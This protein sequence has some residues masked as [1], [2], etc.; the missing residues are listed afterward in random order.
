MTREEEIAFLTRYKIQNPV[1]YVHKFG[2]VEPKD[3]HLSVPVIPVVEPKIKVEIATKDVEVETPKDVVVP[4]Q[5]EVKVV[6]PKGQ[7]K[8]A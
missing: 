7:K 1:K 4:A 8:K 2:D 6:K 3:A 5:E